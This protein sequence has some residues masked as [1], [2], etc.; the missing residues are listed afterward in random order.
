VIKLRAGKSGL[1]F[2]YSSQGAKQMIKNATRMSKRLAFLNDRPL[3]Q[4]ASLSE[5]ASVHPAKTEAERLAAARLVAQLYA[6]EGYLDEKNGNQN[7]N[8]DLQPFY[9]FH[10]LLEEAVVFVAE[11]NGRIWGTLTIIFDS[12]A[13]LPLETLYEPEIAQLRKQK[14][15]LCE[16]CSLAVD[17]RAGRDGSALVLKLFKTAFAYAYQ[18]IGAT[19]ICIT[20]K[21]SH[22]AFYR[23][24]RFEVFGP[25]RRDRRFGDAPTIA[26]RL[27][28][29]QV[30]DFRRLAVGQG[31][32]YGISAYLSEQLSSEDLHALL[33]AKNE[34]KRRSEE[35]LN[36]IL[37]RPAILTEAQPQQRQYL[38]SQFQRLLIERESSADV[39]QLL[40][41]KES[42][43][44]VPLD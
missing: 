15:K 24:L 10:H 28:R 31:R 6:V 4:T 1:V 23:R 11:T 9:T 18:A 5:L 17:P 34:G 13:G 30:E 39:T 41:N 20:L 27:R 21:P 37:R 7:P 36:W 2:R 26:V 40:K 22:G 38:L 25:F 44:P 33:A 32:A 3:E 29:E 12:P 35:V 43:R 42:W 16:F 19:D 8:N 14:R